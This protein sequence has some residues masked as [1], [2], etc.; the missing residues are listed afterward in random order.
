MLS[1]RE[2]LNLD[3][4]DIAFWLRAAR[5]KIILDQI[6]HIQAVR[7]GMAE[8]E[9]YMSKINELKAQMND[10]DGQETIRQNWDDLKETKRG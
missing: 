2:L 1:Y 7:A 9:Y 10:A 3:V 4:R 8:S 5:K 6:R